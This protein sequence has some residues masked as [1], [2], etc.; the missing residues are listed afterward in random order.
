[1]WKLSGEQRTLNLRHLLIS[2]SPT[3]PRTCYVVLRSNAVR[4]VVA[5]AGRCRPGERGGAS[6]GSSQR[7]AVAKD[8][9]LRREISR[10]R[11]NR[12]TINRSEPPD[13]RS[14]EQ[15]ATEA[16]SRKTARWEDTVLP[17]WLVCWIHFFKKQQ[18]S[19]VM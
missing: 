2:N 6:Q 9:M 13:S 8:E 15:R 7:A 16:E 14:T 10:L 18:K 1:M 19:S 5:R 4:S 17:G 11:T 12:G 3:A